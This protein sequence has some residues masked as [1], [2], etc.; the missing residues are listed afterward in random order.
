MKSNLIQFNWEALSLEER[1]R[2][3]RMRKKN[4]G[5]FKDIVVVNNP[6]LRGEV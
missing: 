2:R 4:Y 5:L 6:K 3:V 1:K